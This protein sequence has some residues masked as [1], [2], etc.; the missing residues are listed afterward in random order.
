MHRQT[1]VRLVKTSLPFSHRVT[2][3]IS[4][5]QYPTSHVLQLLQSVASLLYSV[6]TL[7]LFK[8]MDAMSQW[9]PEKRVESSLITKRFIQFMPYIPFSRLSTSRRL[10]PISEILVRRPCV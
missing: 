1:E 7:L 4:H 5:T 9:Y 8:N 2:F 10:D 3:P 6:L